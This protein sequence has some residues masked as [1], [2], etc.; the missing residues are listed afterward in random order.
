MD[1]FKGSFSG[2]NIIDVVQFYCTC[3]YSAEIIVDTNNRKGKIYI[4]KGD[5]YHAE[6]EGLYGEDAFM[7]IITWDKGNLIIE[8]IENYPERTIDK[9]SLNLLFRAAQLMDEKSAGKKSEE[10]DESISEE[11]KEK[12]DKKEFESFLVKGISAFNQK[13]YS[14]ARE[15]WTKAGEINPDDQFINTNL[16][17]LKYI[18]YLNF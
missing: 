2:I 11:L 7:D 1:G 17:L 6:S 4:N 13:D 10:P 8:N 18:N 12:D 14:L 9:A 16:K 5:I 3:K 15:L